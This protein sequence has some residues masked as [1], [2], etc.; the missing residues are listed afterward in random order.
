MYDENRSKLNELAVRNNQYDQISIVIGYNSLFQR[1]LPF[2]E[3]T[4]CIGKYSVSQW[5][6]ICAKVESFLVIKRDSLSNPQTFLANAFFPKSTLDRIK[7]QEEQVIVFSVGQLNVLKKLAIVYGGSE[8]EKNE[9]PIEKIDLSKAFLASQDIHNKFDESSGKNGDLENFCQFIIRN[10]YLNDSQDAASLFVR[11][12]QMQTIHGS[13]VRFRRDEDFGSFF[14]KY[15]GLTVEQSMS[16]CFSLATTFFQDKDLLITRSTV[17]DPATYYQNLIIDSQLTKS[18]IENLVIDCSKARERIL[19]E[20]KVED[21][22]DT[23]F[24]YNLAVFRKTPFVRLSNGKLACAS[25]SCLLEKTTQNFVW[26]PLSRVTGLSD[27]QRAVLV[28][29]LT[30]YRGRV[31]EEYVKDLCIEMAQ[32]NPK[33]QH[34]HISPEETEE[35]EEVGDSLLIEGENLIILEAK[36]RQFNESFKYTGKWSEDERFIDELTRKAVNQIENAACKIRNGSV[37]SLPVKPDSI[38]RIYP[39]IVSYEPVPMHG[40]MQRYIRQR[41]SELGYLTDP[42]YAPV[43]IIHIGDLEKVMESVENYSFID[44]LKAKHSTNGHASETNFNNFYSN[45]VI[46]N[47]VVSN[48]WGRGKLSEFW[49]KVFAPN[50][51]FKSPPPSVDL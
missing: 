29:E 50:F 25:I 32:K 19:E 38:R 22:G 16:L 26:L 39:V 31:F 49:K 40:K 36:S 51:V 27:K 37:T 48:G 28:K 6:E 1:Y 8:V 9:I 7:K 12:Y 41:V 34:L 24:G 10:G 3:L 21:V 43:E 46:T 15:L 2:K 5:L 4:E 35:H 14:S 23:P 13:S 47:R 30:S 42:I 33:T 18:I 44:I 17:I 11:T 45:F 20:M